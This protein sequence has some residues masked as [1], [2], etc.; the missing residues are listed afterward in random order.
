MVTIY[1]Q[2]N[3]LGR[4]IAGFVSPLAQVIGYNRLQEKENQRKLAEEQKNIEKQ[5]KWGTILNETIGNLGPDASS[6]DIARAYSSAISQGIPLDVAK[7]IGALQKSFAAPA[8]SGLGIQSR[9]E[10][11]DLLGR[12]GMNDEQAQREA[13]LY[14]ALPVGGKT[15]Y[16]NYLFDRLQ[17]G[18]LNSDRQ[19][20][21][22]EHVT[23]IP[24]TIEKD[25]TTVSDEIQEFE[26]PKIDTFEGLND[27]ERVARQNDLIKKNTDIYRDNA[28]KARGFDD[29]IRRLGQLD[30]LNESGKLPRGMTKA[31]NINWT[32]G[33]I[34]FPAA[35]NAQTQLFAKTI[36]DFTTKAKD[37]YGSRVTNFELGTFLRRLPTLANTEEGRRLILAQ[38]KTQ[39]EIEKLYYDSLQAVYDKYG[40]KNIDDATVQRISKDLRA[41]DEKKL[42]EQYSN[43]VKSQDVYELKD[44]APENY[45][46]VQSPTGEY[47]Y[48][49]YDQLNA[50]EKKGYKLL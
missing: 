16:A 8:Q 19:G 11:V 43:I 1:Q 45:Y 47:G 5:Q 20:F 49:K 7:D 12:F 44:K 6:I 26:W 3:A 28:T 24:N 17:R 18:Q 22:Q 46:P 34:R 36:N 41:E 27:K 9:D 23:F 39:D 42:I 14:V 50:A 31:L 38:M 40:T 37:T 35:S 2:P 4:G 33:D 15:Q 48:V 21:E 13:D 32:T 10:L 29:E 25:L 30:R